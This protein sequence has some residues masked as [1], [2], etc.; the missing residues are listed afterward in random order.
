MND[1][2]NKDKRLDM[3]LKNIDTEHNALQ[4]EYESIKSVISKNVER[5]FKIFS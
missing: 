5:T 1:I 2:E 3:E 4:Q